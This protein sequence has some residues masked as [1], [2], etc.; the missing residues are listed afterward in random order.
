MSACVTI[1]SKDYSVW[2][3][4]PTFDHLLMHVTW[5][6]QVWPAIQSHDQIYSLCNFLLRKNMS[7]S[8]CVQKSVKSLDT[9][10]MFWT[11]LPRFDIFCAPNYKC[12]KCDQPELN[13]SIKCP[14]IGHIMD[15][16]LQFGC[17]L[18]IISKFGHVLGIIRAHFKFWSHFWTHYGHFWRLCVQNVSVPTSCWSA[19]LDWSSQTSTQF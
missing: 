8:C 5:C 3:A 14:K 6:C 7:S 10:D 15:I 19:D 16:S 13:M 9:L 1:I 4:A 12:P 11:L 17:F 18:D 2:P